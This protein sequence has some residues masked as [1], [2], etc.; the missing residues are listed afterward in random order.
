MLPLDPLIYTYKP[1]QL[2]LQNIYPASYMSVVPE[3]A[4]TS[5]V[6]RID[7]YRNIWKKNKFGLPLM[8]TAF[9]FKVFFIHRYMLINKNIKKKYFDPVSLIEVGLENKSIYI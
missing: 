8:T 7:I 2:I 6:G 4:S 9:I 5:L 3:K 1:D